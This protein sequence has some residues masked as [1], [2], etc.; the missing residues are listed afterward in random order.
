MDALML[1][2]LTGVTVSSVTGARPEV[3]CAAD[4]TIRPTPQ[5]AQVAG[6][7][8]ARV[9][10]GSAESADPMLQEGQQDFGQPSLSFAVGTG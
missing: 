6:A 10:H 4:R 2:L 9:G 8:I 5:G 7:K 1:L 3:A